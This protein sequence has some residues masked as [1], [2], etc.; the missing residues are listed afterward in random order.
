M[1]PQKQQL[2]EWNDLKK[3]MLLN[4]ITY[5]FRPGHGFS[6]EVKTDQAPNNTFKNGVARKHHHCLEYIFVISSA[7]VVRIK[8]CSFFPMSF[9]PWFQSSRFGSRIAYV[10]VPDIVVRIKYCIYFFFL[11]AYP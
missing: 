5:H 8:D 3:L 11:W 2:Q 9:C 4:P 1:V 7:I 10:L 6:P